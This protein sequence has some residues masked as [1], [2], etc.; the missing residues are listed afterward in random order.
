MTHDALRGRHADRLD[1]DPRVLGNVALRFGADQFPQR[2]RPL[3]SALEFDPGVEVLRVLAHDH[4]VDVLVA[5]PDAGVGLARTDARVEI[6]LLAKGDVHAA[7]A[8]PDRRRDRALETDLR[9]AERVEHPRRKRRSL[10][11]EHVDARFLNVPLEPDA[12]VLEDAPRR[13]G[14]FGPGPVARNQRDTIRHPAPFN[15]SLSFSRNSMNSCLLR[16]SGRGRQNRIRE[17][18]GK[19]RTSLGTLP[20]EGEVSQIKSVR[21]RSR[22]PSSCRARRLHLLVS[23]TLRTPCV[24]VLYR[25]GT[26]SRSCRNRFP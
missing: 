2:F 7:E 21:T 15:F 3:A 4:E 20:R 11:P 16:A 14:D 25:R 17:W 18:W 26:G 12:R 6:Q 22:A 9:Q 1:R 24:S 5:G 10:F 13:L 23:P 8:R 19:R